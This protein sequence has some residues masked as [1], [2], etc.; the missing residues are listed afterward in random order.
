MNSFKFRTVSSEIGLKTQNSGVFVKSASE[1]G[2]ITYYG[3]LL[4]IL[5]IE[6]GVGMIVTLFECEWCN[7]DPCNKGIVVDT[8]MLV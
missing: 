3:R 5:E 6:Y 4:H 1:N 7:V 8:A 2:K